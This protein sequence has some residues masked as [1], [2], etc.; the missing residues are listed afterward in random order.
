LITGPG[1]VVESMMA[2]YPLALYVRLGVALTD[3]CMVELPSVSASCLASTD[4]GKKLVLSFSE[5]RW[6]AS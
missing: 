1:A 3:P 5:Y 2:S 6:S 4:V